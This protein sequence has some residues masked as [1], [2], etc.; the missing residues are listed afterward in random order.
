MWVRATLPRV[1]VD[2]LMTLCW[3]YM[4]PI[5]LVNVV[6]TAVWMVVVPEPVG[7]VVAVA[8]TI[9][10]VV[11]VVAFFR[12]VRFHLRRARLRA[13]DYYYSPII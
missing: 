8:L 13:A 6:G 7:R 4:V 11:A 1:R 9:G 3:K 5:A 12:R 10:A 2:Q